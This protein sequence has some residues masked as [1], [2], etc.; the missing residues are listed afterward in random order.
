M[1]GHLEKRSKNSWTI[2]VE[3]GRDPTTGK[4]K[5]IKESFRGTKREAERELAKL[6]TE[7]EKGTYIEPSKLTFG[8]YLL[9]WLEECRARNLAP[10]TLR[11]YG[12]IIRLRVIP[13]LG[14]IPLDKLRPVHL[15][16]F[17]R[18]LV[19]RGRLDRETP[20]SP[21]SIVY[22]HAAGS[23]LYSGERALL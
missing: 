5:R 13:Y 18:E 19:E 8:E 21:A 7:L 16:Q 11:R 20:L 15:Q 12:Q 23:G 10:T 4:R 2:V 1:P 9:Q 14:M 6:I 3:A 22:H 17:Y